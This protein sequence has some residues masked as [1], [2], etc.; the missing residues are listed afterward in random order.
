MKYLVLVFAFIFGCVGMVW[1][2]VTPR[3][4]SGQKLTISTEASKP[5]EAPVTFTHSY[6]LG[7]S[8]Q[9]SVAVGA[10][11]VAPWRVLP[12]QREY[13][14]IGWLSIEKET[15]A[16]RLIRPEPYQAPNLRWWA[17]L[18]CG[19]GRLQVRGRLIFSLPRQG[20]TLID[21]RPGTVGA[22][23]TFSLGST[24]PPQP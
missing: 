19:E 2:Q 15:P 11:Q 10:A 6:D 1:A 14:N 17:C 9:R 21:A 12:V 16:T 23:V 22:G 4:P 13:V 5:T 7:G 24:K 18:W 20:K 8:V 3:P